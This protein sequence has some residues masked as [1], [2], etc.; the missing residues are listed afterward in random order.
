MS[1]QES[2]KPKLV[3]A[4][5]M[6][7]LLALLILKAFEYELRSSY[8]FSSV[9]ACAEENGLEGIAWQW[10]PA[11][12]AEVQ[13]FSPETVQENLAMDC[14][15][16]KAGWLISGSYGA[17]GSDRPSLKYVISGEHYS[18]PDPHLSLEYVY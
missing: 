14:I 10:R 4:A 1:Y 6:L 12:D 2:R 8:F 3:L 9:E 7:C 11:F 13:V 16:R 18:P 5:V 17:F 15:N